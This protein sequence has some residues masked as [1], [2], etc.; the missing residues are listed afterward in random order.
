MYYHTIV[1][2]LL[3]ESH[4]IG[5]KVIKSF[6]DTKLALVFALFFICHCSSET[7]HLDDHSQTASYVITYR[8]DSQKTFEETLDGLGLS[9]HLEKLT[10][11]GKV[12]E[13]NNSA[14]FHISTASF[15][16]GTDHLKAVDQWLAARILIHAEPNHRSVLQVD[17]D[18]GSLALHYDQDSPQSEP[19]YQ[20]IDFVPG[21]QYLAQAAVDPDL[22]PIIAVLDAGIDRKHEALRDKIWVNESLTTRCQ[23]D[24][25]GCNTTKSSDFVLGDGDTHPIGTTDHGQSCDHL[26]SATLMLQC[27]HGTHA[28]GIISSSPQ[29]NYGGICPNCKILPIKI[30]SL[31]GDQ[32]PGILDSSIISALVYLKDLR[33]NG[34]PVRIAN[35]SFGKFQRSR[36]IS[37]L[38]EELASMKDGQ[39]VLIVAAAGNENTSEPQYPAAH[40]DVLAVSNLDPHTKIKQPHSNFGNWVDISAPGTSLDSCP[41]HQPGIRS[42]IPGG[43]SGCSRGT[44]ISAPVISGI[45]GLVLTQKPDLTTTELRNILIA[46]GD[47]SIYDVPQNTHFLTKIDGHTYPLLGTGMVNVKSAL[48][49]GNATN[50]K[51][52]KEHTRISSHGCGVLG[53][54]NGIS[55]SGMIA[56]ML[57]LT[58]IILT[59]KRHPRGKR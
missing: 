51:P 42:A 55:A 21:L 34:V 56:W 45:A 28:A 58:P 4:H 50:W 26:A 59:M 24:Y 22:A 40:Q 57:I 17:E 27:R 44:S 49:R 10:Y 35:A 16:P 43:G 15:Y 9:A 23:D 48:T 2:S 11:L 3:L 54:S 20:A 32:S 39:G 53:E 14:S 1:F 29:E 46:S 37:L 7:N 47:S 12:S 6:P 31:Q 41:P 38:I 13:P 18:F 36:T 19:W 30:M 33:N 52:G 8:S 25:F 5:S